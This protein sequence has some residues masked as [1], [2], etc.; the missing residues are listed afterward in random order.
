MTTVEPLT[1]YHPFVAATLGVP[2]T[3]EFSYGRKSWGYI[4]PSFDVEHG[5]VV[6]FD[7]R[8]A[9]YFVEARRPTKQIWQAFLET[10][11]TPETSAH[12]IGPVLRKSAEIAEAVEIEAC[13]GRLDD[14]LAIAF[15]DQ[16]NARVARTR[17]GVVAY[18]DKAP[19]P[20]MVT[21]GAQYWFGGV[22]E[23]RTLNIAHGD[24]TEKLRDA[25]DAV[26]DYCFTKDGAALDRLEDAVGGLESSLPG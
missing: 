11:Y 3:A 16:M 10:F 23:G 14:I 6:G 24:D 1:L 9:T 8:A 13:G 26:V 21:D 4:F 17:S 7:E 25:A 2:G 15:I 20:P 19:P 22:G 18:V 12:S 5:Y